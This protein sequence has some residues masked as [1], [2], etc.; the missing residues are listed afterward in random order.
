VFF[1]VAPS[2]L[3]LRSHDA[4]SGA[5][6][7]EVQDSVT[8]ARAGPGPVDFRAARVVEDEF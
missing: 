6:R 2:A 1:T 5:R 8:V 4:P 7:P 3:V